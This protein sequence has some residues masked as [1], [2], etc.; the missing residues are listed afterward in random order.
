MR[1]TVQREKRLRA[2][3]GFDDLLSKLDEA[4][5]QPGGVLLAETIRARYPVALIDEFQDTDPQQYRIFRTL[6]INQPEQALFLIGD[7]KQAIYAFRGA[8]IFTYLRARNEVS[9]HYTLDTNWRSSPEMVGS[10]N[11]LFLSS[12]RLFCSRRSP[13]SQLSLLRPI[14]R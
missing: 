8:D 3:L 7:P 9:A 5:Q 6:Y 1:A 12:I 10:V 13:F 4:L 2:L 14:S 11:R